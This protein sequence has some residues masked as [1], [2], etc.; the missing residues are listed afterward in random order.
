MARR[1]APIMD[2]STVV[3]GKPLAKKPK[4]IIVSNRLPITVKHND[5]GDF[6]IAPSAGGLVS[7]LKSLHEQSAMIWIGHSGLFKDHPDYA[8]LVER[9]AEDRLHAVPLDADTYAGYYRGISNDVIWPLFH[10]F[11]E[12]MHFT[13]RDWQGYRRANQAFADKVLEL[14][15]PGDS[16]W[17]HDYQLMLAPGMLRRALPELKIAYFHHIPFPSSEVLRACPGRRDMLTGLLGADYIGFHTF[18]YARHFLSSVTRVLGADVQMDEVHFDSRLIKVGAHPLGVDAKGIAEVSRGIDDSNLAEI[19]GAGRD[20]KIL[21]LGIDRLD[22]T[23]G[24]PLRLEAFRVFLRDNPE[25]VGKATLIQQCVPSREKIGAYEELKHTIEQLVGEI[26]GAFAQPGYT[27]IQY[28]Y[29]SLP[30]EEVVALLK[31]ARVALVTPLRDGLNLVCKEYVAAHEDLEGVL[32]LS[33]F[34]GSAVEM[35]EALLVNPFD[36]RKVAQAMLAAVQ[37]APETRRQRMR[38][39]RQRVCAYDNVAWSQS[40]LDAWRAAEP[41]AAAKSVK[42]AGKAREKA[43]TQLAGARRLF[44]FLDNDGTLTPIAS[45]PEL[46]IP[47]KKT[48]DLLRRFG[49]FAN[50]SITVITGRPRSF[51]EE[52]FLDL[53]VNVIA[54]HGVFAWQRDRRSWEKFFETD[55]QVESLKPE[56][57]RMFNLYVRYVPGSHVEEKETSLVWH[58]RNAVQEFA[59]AQAKTLTESLQQLLSKTSLSVYMGKKTV[60]VRQVS[61]NKGNAVERLLERLG[62]RGPEDQVATFGDDTTDEDM[63]RAPNVTAAVHVGAPNAFAQHYLTSPDDLRDFLAELRRRLQKH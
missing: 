24:V 37:M 5:D 59:A 60:E 35:G 8:K 29:R 53:P 52:H 61:A 4:L 15:E 1:P 45:R 48:L 7:G 11:P 36:V 57:L 34:A 16:V 44:L 25:Y 19:T 28:L 39:L 13:D 21:F 40:F 47:P 3:W 31:A 42:L 33:E 27:P 30:F 54:E 17:V 23:K 55:S 12:M 18:D 38:L 9:L 41:K 56:I 63:H 49:E 62:G 50:V 46:A 2:F 6:H 20:G 14:A 26:N 51:C 32:I 10:Y 43:L 58:Y 22:Y